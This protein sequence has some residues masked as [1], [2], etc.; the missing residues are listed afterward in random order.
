[1]QLVKSTILL[2]RAHAIKKQ[3]RQLGPTQD[4]K[5][6]ED[7]LAGIEHILQAQG[8]DNQK[9]FVHASRKVCDKVKVT[10]KRD[11]ETRQLQPDRDDR[12]QGKI[13]LVPEI[14]RRH[15]MVYAG[16]T[17]SGRSV[18]ER[19]VSGAIGTLNK[20]GCRQGEGRR[21]TT[22]TYTREVA[23]DRTAHPTITLNNQAQAQAHA[24]T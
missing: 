11:K 17:D 14:G 10:I 13:V 8:H 19:L 16:G 3:T 22:G 21:E 24:H 12:R 1:M 2:P 6:S 18:Q 9:H 4:Q 15:Q 7:D 5:R 20:R 23:V